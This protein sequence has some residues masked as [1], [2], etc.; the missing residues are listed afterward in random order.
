MRKSPP[1]KRPPVT[2]AKTI[3]RLVVYRFLLDELKARGTTHI[4]SNEIAQIV[5]NTAAQ[6][7]RDLM[8]VGYSGN[9]R[10]GYH[11]DDLLKAIRS[12]LEPT[13]GITMAVA[14]VGNLGRALLG[15]F[16]RLEPRFHVVGA[17]DNDDN[18]AGR[19][20]AGYS[21]RHI[22]ELPAELARTPAQLGVITVPT[23][24]AQKIANLLANANVRGIV[25]FAPVPLHVPPGV[26]L[27]NMHITATFEKVAYFSRMN[28]QGAGL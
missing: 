27:E 2:S 5:G 3:E 13:E 20:I 9:T 1:G 16:S 22:R 18:K 26:W 7:R 6:V 24:E 15:Y 23:D 10:N 8:V 4:Y 28:L 21:I 25:N 14:G 19:A 11:V 12:L 17:F